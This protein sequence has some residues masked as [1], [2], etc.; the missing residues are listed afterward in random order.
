MLRDYQQINITDITAMGQLLHELQ[1][2]LPRPSIGI[3]ELIDIRVRLEVENYIQGKRHAGY[4]LF[5]VDEVEKLLNGRGSGVAP[6]FDAEKHVQRAMSGFSSNR[7][8]V[9]VNDRQVTDIDEKVAVADTTNVSF[10]Q[11]MPL[12]GG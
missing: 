3:R 12:V 7:F 5:A 6:Q 9:I 11:L 4:E 10:M 8:F 2:S 1:M